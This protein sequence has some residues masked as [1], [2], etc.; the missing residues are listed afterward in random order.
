MSVAERCVNLQRL[1][2]YSNR[3]TAISGLDT[4]QVRTGDVTSFYYGALLWQ[5]LTELGLNC[6]A[7]TSIDSGLKG[8][9]RFGSVYC[10]SKSSPSLC[11]LATLNLAGNALTCLVPG[12]LALP[13]LAALN[14]AGNE[15][16]SVEH[17]LAL[18]DAPALRELTLCDVDHK[19][20]PL[21]LVPGYMA[22]VMH[23]LP[24]LTAVR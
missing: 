11:R 4:L 14:L 8:L 6:N 13:A 19:T 9:Q 2:L 5:H 3:I 20:A 18:T 7:I 22:C 16:A 12:E 24:A 23:L 17:L 10:M 21:C 15:F 1:F